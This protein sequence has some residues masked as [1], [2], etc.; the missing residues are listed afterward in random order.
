MSD[1]EPRNNPSDRRDDRAPWARWSSPGTRM[2]VGIAIGVAIGV[3]FM[4]SLGAA[5]LAMGMGVGVVFGAVLSQADADS[6]D[7]S[8]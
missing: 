1:D 7:P 8:S 2:A 4:P 6:D 3:A 5:G